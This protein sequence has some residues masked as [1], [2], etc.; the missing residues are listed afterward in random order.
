MINFFT[1]L[2]SAK[3]L[4]HIFIAVSSII[5]LQ[6]EIAFAQSPWPS[7]TWNAAV[8]LTPVM[9]ATGLND[10]SGLHW[11]PDLNRLYVIHGSGGLRVLELNKT[12]NLFTQIANLSL[13]GGPEDVTQVNYTV[14]EFYTIDENNYEIRKYTNTANFSSLTLSKSWNL[15]ISPSPMTNTGNTG[16]E[17]IAF[18]PD[19]FL[20]T[21]GFISQSTGQAY[22]S[23]KGM[24]GLLFIAHQEGG[25]IWVFDVNPNVS[26]DFSFV[27]K[28][29]TNRDESCDLEFD[30]STGLLYILHNKDVNFL[31][32]TDLKS[33]VNGS[34]RKFSVMKEYTIANPS[35]SINIE[36]FA[37]APKCPDASNVSV[38]LCRD[39]ESTNPVN[40]QTDCIRWYQ[41][42]EADG[43]C[44]I[45]SISSDFSKI[46]FDIKIYPNP[47]NQKIIIY[48]NEI[49]FKDAS[50][51]IY[52][53][54]GQISFQKSKF[55]GSKFDL[56]V[57]DFE[58]GMYIIEITH[59]NNIATRKWFKN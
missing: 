52:N 1:Y 28:Y 4:K 46:D 23:K 25:Y 29:K 36:G 37:I 44:S 22:T 42:F 34:V 5:L 16:P 54:Q 3:Q 43:N 45:N 10:L 39:V 57:S 18:V 12:S 27:G 33:T 6:F 32:I 35:G 26:D 31:E 56:N 9:N 14:D 48:F 59:D 13:K 49:G 20:T 7:E 41:P 51:K 24:G 2:I 8:N 19:K 17:G 11:N 40:E 38:W 50:I 21:S 30:R 55:Q 15:L 47:G 58:N 53:S